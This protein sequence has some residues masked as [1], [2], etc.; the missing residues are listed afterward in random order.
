MV[1]T[2]GSQVALQAAD[3]MLLSDD[4][5][6]LA[7]AH[8]LVRRMAWV[9]KQNLGFALGA[10]AVLVVMGVFF[11]LPLPLAVIGHEGRTLLVVLNG[12]RLLRDPI[13]VG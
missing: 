3:V 11:N 10:M 12:R 4:M 2:A 6:R 1:G 8:R 7:L 13:R 5:A 9:I